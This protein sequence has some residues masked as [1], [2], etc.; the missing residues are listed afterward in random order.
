MHNESSVSGCVAGGSR[1]GDGSCRRC[2]ATHRRGENY[3]KHSLL[4]LENYELERRV[5]FMTDKNL[6]STRQ[7]SI[8]VINMS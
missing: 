2:T 7:L 4:S 6:F 3:F 1:R 8:T 5:G